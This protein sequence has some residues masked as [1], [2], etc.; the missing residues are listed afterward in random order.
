MRERDLM[1]LAR[2]LPK[3]QDEVERLA[4]ASGGSLS[5]ASRRQLYTGVLDR[6]YSGMLSQ[7]GFEYIARE[8]QHSYGR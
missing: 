8:K 1:R 3:L 6:Y 2:V 7:Y 5:A 4:K